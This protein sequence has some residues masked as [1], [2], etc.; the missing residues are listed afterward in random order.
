MP[1]TEFAPAQINRASRSGQCPSR[2]VLGWMA[3]HVR[4]DVLAPTLDGTLSLAYARIMGTQQLDVHRAPCRLLPN[5][6]INFRQNSSSTAQYWHAPNPPCISGRQ[7]RRAARLPGGNGSRPVGF[8]FLPRS[9]AGRDP[10]AAR[11]Y[12]C[13][14]PQQGAP[15]II[16]FSHNGKK[17]SFKD[18]DESPA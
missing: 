2:G 13:L 4:L 16:I 10:T 7:T 18:N 3:R 9:L 14:L 1:K 15:S 12:R 17:G 5:H 11:T 8:G 6:G